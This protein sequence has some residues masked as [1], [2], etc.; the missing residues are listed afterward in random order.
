LATSA[1]KFSGGYKGSA[2]RRHRRASSQSGGTS[3]QLSIPDYQ[4]QTPTKQYSPSAPRT[5]VQRTIRR[6]KAYLAPLRDAVNTAYTGGYEAIFGPDGQHQKQVEDELRQRYGPEGVNL[7]S[8]ALVQRDSQT[9]NL[10]EDP[11]AEFAIG[12][13]ATAGVGGVANL[14]RGGGTAALTAAEAQAAKAGATEAASQATGGSARAALQSLLRGAVPKAGSA[15]VP[16]AERVAQAIERVPKS[17]RTVG[18]AASYP[19]R[20]PVKA[21]LAIQAFPAALHHDPGEFTKALSGGGIYANIFNSAAQHA[22]GVLGEAVSLPAQV[23]PSAFLVGKAGMNAAKGNHDEAEALWAEYKRTGL[24]PP[25]LQGN[26]SEA[27]GHLGAHPVYGGLELSGLASAAGRTAGAAS[28]ELSGGRIG[29]QA[30]PDLR[31]KG[32]NVTV[33]RRYSPDLVRQMFQ[34]GWDAKKGN[35]VRPNSVRG[36]H[37]LKEAVNRHQ[38]SR[39]EIRRHHA[40]EEEQFL[41]Q[42]LPRRGPTLK[43]RGKL[44]RASAEVVHLAVERIARHP[45]TFAAD[46][47]HYR[48]MLEEVAIERRPDG[49]PLLDRK[50]MKANEDLRK[51]LDSASDLSPDRVAATVKAANNFIQHHQDTTAEMV[52]LGLLDPDQAIRASAIPFARVHRGAKHDPGLDRLVNDKGEPIDL[53]ELHESMK[54]Q[55][56]EPGFLSHREPANSDFYPGPSFGG[57]ELPKGKRTGAATAAGTQ[58]GG[59]SGVEHL[60]RQLRRS[61]GLVDK[62]HAWNEAV[63]RF[64]IELPHV[65]TFAD[66]RAAL[67]DPVRAGLDPALVGTIDKPG[68]IA[69]PRYPFTAKKIERLGALEHQDPAIVEETAAGLLHDDLSA[70]AKGTLDDK[71]EVVLMPTKVAKQ[72]LEETKPQGTGGKLAQGFTQ[73][74]KSTW[75]PLSVGFHIGNFDNW[76]RA[77]LSGS[78]HFVA[79]AKVAKRLS[80]EQK[81]QVLAGAH[82]SSV[83]NLAVHRSLDQILDGQNRLSRALLDMAEWSRHRGKKQSLARALPAGFNGLTQTL[84]NAN[85]LVTERLPQYGSLG[86]FALHEIHDMQGSWV[87]TI[88]HFD[89]GADE[90][91]KG[92]ADPARMTR[93]AKELERIYGNYSHLSPT[94]R[95]FWSTA[96]PFW[97]WARA[98]LKFVYITMPANHPI[99]TAML[100]AAVQ[101]EHAHL[102]AWGL[103]PEGDEPVESY[104]KGA[105]PLE[106]GGAFPVSG[107][108]SFGFA[109]DPVENLPGMVLPQ[110]RNVLEPLEGRNGF[111]EPIKASGGKRVELAAVGFLGSVL[112]GMNLVVQQG[113][114]GEVA[115]DFNPHLPHARSA[116]DVRQARTQRQYISV[117]VEGSASTGGSIW[118]GSTSET[119][120]I[121]GGSAEVESGVWK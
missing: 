83:N 24:L 119:E 88:R 50:Q 10:K 98:A 67:R 4:P 64:G 81:E 53:K 75:L 12:T 55:G 115:F 111:G 90:F 48:K 102:E 18:R 65:K 38:S 104:M 108:S 7:I 15:G 71:A 77:A 61:R 106:G 82:F 97:T 23:L 117:P 120:G 1:D 9:Q 49:K 91:A 27:L 41:K 87:K 16:G 110:F 3:G 11:I 72:F 92:L 47:Q 79:G 59:I 40:R 89:E 105:I 17:V 94:A 56:I 107:Y 36:S 21:P 32:T 25:L 63:S 73:K 100:T 43:G 34:R 95:R 121:W 68:L 39:E 22:P 26:L 80:G 37:Y 113:P 35:E 62:A 13:L 69:V 66:A 96:M 46:L 28:R 93:L 52:D 86:K 74:V 54:R 99:Q 84:L 76:L 114:D 33:S 5:P 30:R 101:A 78:Y 112:P 85:R 51:Q 116:E 103:N 109:G 44:D 6:E 42:V 57:V 58:L 31:I 2:G 14:L 29:G 60:L 45:E 8:R 20:H 118:G 70:A 19:V